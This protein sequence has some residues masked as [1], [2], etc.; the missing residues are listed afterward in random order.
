M[1]ASYS[2]FPSTKIYLIDEVQ[3]CELVP[4]VFSKLTHHVVCSSYPV[5][6]TKGFE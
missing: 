3:K 4:N 5:N 2:A 1:M 6:E